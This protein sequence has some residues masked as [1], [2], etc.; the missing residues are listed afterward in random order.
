MIVIVSPVLFAEDHYPLGNAPLRVDEV[1]QSAAFEKSRRH[2]KVMPGLQAS[3]TQFPALS[4]R[5]SGSF[6][7]VCL[8]PTR[9]CV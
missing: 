1:P 4:D 2:P 5:R 7:T 8:E 6:L 9:L 3:L